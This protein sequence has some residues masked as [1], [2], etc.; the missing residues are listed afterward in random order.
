MLCTQFIDFTKNIIS[1]ITT[2]VVNADPYSPSDEPTMVEV[3]VKT[4][5]APKQ[6]SRSTVSD[7]Q[8]WGQLLNSHSGENESAFGSFDPLRTLHFLG[9]ELQA[10]MQ[11]RMPGIYTV[12]FKKCAIACGKIRLVK[13]K[14]SYFLLNS[15]PV[16]NYYKI[17]FLHKQS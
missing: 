1:E 7:R 13:T 4:S 2:N 14:L 11:A 3:T 10:Y 17:V 5:N 8:P 16:G 6:R 12:C 9:R 15:L